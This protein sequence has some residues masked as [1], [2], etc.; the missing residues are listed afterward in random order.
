[1][2]KLGRST[3]WLSY[4]AAQRPTPKTRIFYKSIFGINRPFFVIRYSNDKTFLDWVG[5]SGFII[6]AIWL[7]ENNFFRSLQLYGLHTYFGIAI[8]YSFLSC[9]GIYSSNYLPWEVKCYP[10]EHWW[11]S[12]FGLAMVVI[13]EIIR[14]LAIITAG[15]AFTHLIKVRHEEHH[16][17]VRHGV[18]RYVRHP[19]YS[20]FLIWS[21]GTQIMLCNPISSVV[22]ALV[23]WRF[24]SQRIPYEEYFLRQFFGSHY[25]AYAHENDELAGGIGNKIA[26]NED[27]LPY[28]SMNLR[29]EEGHFVARLAGLCSVPTKP[30]MK[31]PAFITC[32]DLK[33]FVHINIPCRYSKK[34]VSFKC[35]YLGM[36]IIYFALEYLVTTESVGKVIIQHSLLFMYVD[37]NSDVSVNDDRGPKVGGEEAGLLV[38]AAYAEK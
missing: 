8:F 17:L 30:D 6:I 14:K 31:T 28:S 32:V 19:G 18:Y 5:K 36:S 11:I 7:G 29:V 3:V 26:R 23:V 24:F 16:E 33:R 35:K 1:M 13:G 15:R 20:G 38:S 4:S 21:V 9:L 10:Q 2:G 37:R 22:F 27:E 12:N 34:A 25:D